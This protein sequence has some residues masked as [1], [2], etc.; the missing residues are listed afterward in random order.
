MNSHHHLSRHALAMRVHLQH[1]CDRMR[2]ALRIIETIAAATPDPKALRT[3]AQ[4]ARTALGPSHPPD[5][6]LAD[7]P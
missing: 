1:E 4:I 6:L 3:I 5:T 2:D 7:E